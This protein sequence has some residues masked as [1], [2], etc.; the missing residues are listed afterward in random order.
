L[1]IGSR[2][3]QRGPTTKNSSSGD[4]IFVARS[5][6]VP[7][8]GQHRIPHSTKA[9]LSMI[10]DLEWRHYLTRDGQSTNDMPTR[11]AVA[12][13]GEI[14]ATAAFDYSIQETYFQLRR[15]GQGAHPWWTFEDLGESR[16]TYSDI[17]AT[18]GGIFVA[19]RQ[20]DQAAIARLMTKAI[21]SRCTT[22]MATM[23]W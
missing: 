18:E 16:S 22:W 12:P 7:R 11:V 14:Y 17:V 1:A 10:F 6:G 9:S 19:G 2:R 15:I 21:R 20:D 5:V 3:V 23:R 4:E 13:N 8:R